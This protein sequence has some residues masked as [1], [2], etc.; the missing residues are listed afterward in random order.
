MRQETEYPATLRSRQFGVRIFLLAILFFALGLACK[1]LAP[2]V[3]PIILAAT[4]AALFQPVRH[5]LAHVLGE[6][7]N[8]IATLL[9]LGVAFLI[10]LPLL[11]VTSA[12]ID[13]GIQLTAQ[14]RI[15]IAQGNLDAIQ[16]HSLIETILDWIREKLPFVSVE[17]LDIRNNLME[18]SR[19]AS[20]T[21]LRQ[22]AGL[23]G[24][25]APIF[26]N[27]LIM[28]FVL[29]FFFSRGEAILRKIQFLSPLREKQ[30]E[31]IFQKIR[32][33]SRSVLVG[34]LLTAIL[35]GFVGGIGLLLVG[36]PALFW[37]SMIAFASLVPVV[38]TFLVWGPAAGYLVLIG[39]WKSAV[40]LS[41]WCLILV[42]SID[43]F[44]R[45]M[46]MKGEAGMSPFYIFLSILG[47]I[48]L[49]GLV[50]IL[51]G[52]LILAFAM[53]MLAM[54]EDEFKSY[55]IDWHREIK[56]PAVAVNPHDT[57]RRRT[58]L[59]AWPHVKKG[60]TRS[61]VRAPGPT[62]P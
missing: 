20:E 57:T 8:L 30:E 15:W 50:G 29:F 35:Q 32:A 43:N 33:V 31:H 46:L 60:R 39:S 12:L 37:G 21:L 56:P 10:V 47:G 48:K 34:A 23:V 2:F 9:I 19:T 49:F 13:Q 1:L 28:M 58:R 4:L 54:Y 45:P 17:A 41:L 40:F 52:P 3:H 53:V 59:F 7:P 5:R 22:G 51:Y 24:T 18:F 42:T 11:F 38:G 44:L 14:I 36:L 26:F 61:P 6:R 55:L 62:R 25:L 27:F 16:E